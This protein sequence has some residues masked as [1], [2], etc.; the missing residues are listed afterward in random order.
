MS[1]AQHGIYDFWRYDYMNPCPQMHV[2]THRF[3]GKAIWNLL[4]EWG[5]AVV[6]AN[7]PMTYPTEAVNGIML[8]GYM[9]PD[10]YANVTYPASFK[11]ELLQAIPNYQIDLDPAVESEQIGNP[12]LATLEMTRERI[13]LL[14][15]LMQKSWDF[16]FIVFTGADRIQHVRWQEVVRFHPQAV[17]Y[18]QM[19]DEALG[20]VLANLSSEDLLMVVSDHG[21]Q[22]AQRQFY[23]QEY[24]R[25]KGFLFVRDG[26]ALRHT[27]FQNRLAGFMRK[28]IWAI[29]L[30]G[31]PTLLRRQLY[32]YGLKAITRRPVAVKIPDLDWANTCAWIPSASGDVAGYADIFLDDTMTEE[33]IN[34]LLAELRAIRDPVTGH[35]L[36]AEAYREDVFG[37]GSFA[38]KERHLV[39]IANEHIALRVELGHSNLWDT[40][41]PYGIHHP[42]GVLY[43][44]G[45]GT[46]RGV[47]IAPVHVYDVV[48]TI[49]SAMGLS[50]YP[51]L[52]GRVIEEAFERL[53]TPFSRPTNGS[54]VMSK[55]TRLASHSPD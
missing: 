25:K 11:E 15:F 1:P 55:L 5:K 6:V 36:I 28:P 43:L 49:F 27:E 2:V 12:L 21:F 34:A 42:D 51:G 45:A 19:L 30:Q 20:T 10:M 3:G 13:A 17:A 54:G 16:F 35:A 26:N 40:C 38:P 9:A 37:S 23:I 39:V 14:R 52:E 50:P 46:K 18:Y 31:F 29:G 33:Q 8:S 7:I 53:P 32:R 41:K 48:P 47:M 4:S 22:G 24:L 44:Y